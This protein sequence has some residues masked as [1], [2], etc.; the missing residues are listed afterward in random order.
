MSGGYCEGVA[1]WDVFGQRWTACWA[2]LDVENG[3]LVDQV[4]SRWDCVRCWTNQ[5]PQSL[6]RCRAKKATSRH[7]TNFLVVSSPD[8]GSVSVAIRIWKANGR[9]DLACRRPQAI[10]MEA[11][12]CSHSETSCSAPQ[13]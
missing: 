6:A 12:S 11:K 4:R 7:S 10:R 3:H 1:R 5:G 13:K 2:R 8:P 9:S